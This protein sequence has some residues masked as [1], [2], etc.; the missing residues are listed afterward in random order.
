MISEQE[1]IDIA[2][3]NTEEAFEGVKIELDDFY[4]EDD[5]ADK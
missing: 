5:D 1:A 2:L 4:D 3:S